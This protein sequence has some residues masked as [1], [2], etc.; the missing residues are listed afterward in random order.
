MDQDLT[1]LAYQRQK[2]I[3][4]FYQIPE[5]SLQKPC[6]VNLL[7]G[8][9]GTSRNISGLIL[10]S[11][12]LKNGLEQEQIKSIVRKWNI[13]NCEPNLRENQIRN[14]FKSAFTTNTEGRP[15]YDYGCNNRLSAFCIPE[16]K[17]GC[18][19][20]QNYIKPN[21][22]ILEPNYISLKWQHVL[23]VREF[24][25]IA[26][27]IPYIERKRQ[28]KR[29]SRLYAGRREYSAISGINQRYIAEILKNLSSYGLIWYK[30]GIGRNWE[31]KASEVK[32]ILP[33]PEIPKEFSEDIQDLKRYKE[34]N[35][36][37]KKEVLKIG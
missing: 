10:A 4:R 25:M 16:G 6:I 23:T 19:Y 29:G 26:Y 3:S 7:A 27:F 34:L 36:K 24:S 35:K 9:E 30:A 2:D 5:Q 13:E 12:F 18:I 11:E 1:L 21:I 15:K 33:P 31:K 8:D 32:R 17:K 14:I 28:F 37:L 20:Y 22:K